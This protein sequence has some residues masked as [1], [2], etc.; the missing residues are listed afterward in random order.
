M[1]GI[2]THVRAL[3][4]LAIAQARYY[5]LRVL[6]AV[7]GIA[8]A[9]MLITLLVGMGHGVSTRGIQALDAT[10]RELWMS[11]PI[12][13]APG[14]VGGVDNPIVDAHRVADRVES[15]PGV[16]GAEALSF[17]AVYVSPDAS[18]FTTVVGVGMTGTSAPIVPDRGPGFRASDIHYANGTYDGPMTR[19][20]I[21]DER[22]AASLGVSVN[23][24]LYVGGTIA[25]ARENRFRVVGVS[26]TFSSVIGTSTVTLHLSELQELTGTTGTDTASIIAISVTADA[27]R[28]AVAADLERTYPGY[29]VR[30]NREQFDAVVGR[31]A[32]VIASTIAIVIV[33]I[34]TGTTLV[35]NVHVRLVYTQRAELAALKAAGISS[36]TLAGIVTIQGIGVGM[37]GGMLGV[38]A[39][40][41]VSGGLNRVVSSV[42]GYDSLIATPLWVYGVGMA[43][44][45]SM[46]AVAA[47]IASWQVAQI[48]PVEQLK[49][50]F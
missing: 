38:L 5:W 14:A 15:H 41:L 25:N 10:N 30:T 49:R 22:T 20:I 21:V 26:S 19:E 39:T 31:Q 12:G 50:E 40:P 47:A 17:Q 42:V 8:L 7:V 33:G 27:D 44:A 16:R 13:F 9:V 36:R 2:P 1:R 35:I 43:I 11:A 32:S 24:T 46:A 34:L 6:I 23:D 3:V 4:S 45:L 48:N 18:E 29:S 37:A 28:E